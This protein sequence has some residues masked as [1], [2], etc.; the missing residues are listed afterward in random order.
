MAVA[1]L[2]V[3]FIKLLGVPDGEQEGKGAQQPDSWWA[4]TSDCVGRSPFHGWRERVELV[5]LPLFAHK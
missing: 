2:A 3:S 4:D 5:Q 1:L